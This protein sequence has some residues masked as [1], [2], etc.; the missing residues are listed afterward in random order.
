M[1]KNAVHP[2]EIIKCDVLEPLNLTVSE[3]AERLGFSRVTL[4]RVVNGNARISAQ[5]ALRLEQA[6]VGNAE[7]W[8]NLQTAY[9][10][11][12]ARKKAPKGVARLAA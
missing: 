9:E 7:T 11:W 6:G 12:M 10:L 8:M 5:L 3:A 4:S 2:G 1:I